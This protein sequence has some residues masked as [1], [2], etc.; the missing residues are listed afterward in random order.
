MLALGSTARG[1]GGSTC[2][3]G[4]A[5]ELRDTLRQ[6]ACRLGGNRTE[7][8]VF[9]AH[10]RAKHGVDVASELHNSV[11]ELTVARSARIM[12]A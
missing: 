7:G 12:P 2:S 10:V 8:D 9:R 3:P 1:D 6:S 4:G 11:T 5:T